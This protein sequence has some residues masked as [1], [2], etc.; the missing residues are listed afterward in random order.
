MLLFCKYIKLIFKE[1]EMSRW[2]LKH[3][4]KGNDEMSYTSVL[5]ISAQE[6]RVYNEAGNTS[7]GAGF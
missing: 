7:A 5:E 1:N 6:H 2:F 4:G 3:Q